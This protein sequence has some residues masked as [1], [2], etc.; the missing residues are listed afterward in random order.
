MSEYADGSGQARRPRVGE[1]PAQV[2][3][4]VAIALAAVALIAGFLIL[5]SISDGG[6]NSLDVP[7][8]GVVVDDT[9]LDAELP[10]S[11]TTVPLGVVDTTTSTTEPPLVT[12]GASVVV[13]NANGIGGSAGE[14]TR[15]LEAGAGFQMVDPVDASSAV[16]ILD[17][18]VVY[19]DAGVTG[20]QAVAESLAKVLGGIQV[21]PLQGAAPTKDGTL[22]GAAVLLMLGLDNA[23][24]TI[25]QLVLSTS[26]APS[27]IPSPT[28][29]PVAGATE[30]SAP[31]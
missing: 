13:A 8:G 28:N 16:G 23:G 2:S 31:G 21:S 29:P 1:P 20:A 25:D 7:G 11:A 15:T 24:K 9:S 14:M 19:Y 26:A 18:S 10:T 30:S 6:Q 17:V 27:A 4:G 5:R 22:S 3:G 12:T